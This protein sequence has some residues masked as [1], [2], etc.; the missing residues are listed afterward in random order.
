MPLKFI[1]SPRQTILGSLSNSS[2][3]FSPITPPVVSISVLVEG[4][5]EGS[6]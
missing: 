1:A 3:S 5:E 4:T 6:A 2:V